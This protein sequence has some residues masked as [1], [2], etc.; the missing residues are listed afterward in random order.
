MKYST[1]YTGHEIRRKATLRQNSRLLPAWNS[2]NAK[3]P[4]ECFQWACSLYAYQN[5]GKPLIY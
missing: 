3:A 2:N 1:K 4:E 5:G